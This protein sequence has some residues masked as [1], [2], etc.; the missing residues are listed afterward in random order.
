M[1]RSRDDDNN[2]L[3]NYLGQIKNIISKNKEWSKLLKLEQIKQMTN[4][5]IEECEKVKKEEEAWEREEEEEDILKRWFKVASH[6]NEDIIRDNLY[7]ALS[8]T[9]CGM[10]HEFW[11]CE[12]IDLNFVTKI[13][14]DEEVCFYERYS[15][16]IG[17]FSGTIYHLR[18]AIEEFSICD[19]CYEKFGDN[20]VAQRIPINHFIEQF[21]EYLEEEEQ[22]EDKPLYGESKKKYRQTFLLYTSLH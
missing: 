14:C 20:E 5:Y 18:F 4:E 9:L 1:K 13:P 3:N 6:E 2:D 8:K 21:R 7:S 12:D 22:E 15:N 11:Y 17:E 10:K 19:Q 16:P